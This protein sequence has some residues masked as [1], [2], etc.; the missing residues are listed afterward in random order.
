[1]RDLS[2]SRVTRKKGR[3]SATLSSRLNSGVRLPVVTFRT[4][5]DAQ[6]LKLIKAT[7]CEK[8]AQIGGFWEVSAH[9]GKRENCIIR[10]KYELPVWHASCT[11]SG[12]P[13]LGPDAFE[14]Y[15]TPSA[16][17]PG[18]LFT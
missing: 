7:K 5:C 17:S 1:M 13:S 6:A 2:R 12:N 9:D 14:F 4:G 3:L 18:D 10:R 15:S 16:S 11:V 8:T